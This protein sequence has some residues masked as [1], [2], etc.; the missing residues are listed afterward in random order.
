MLTR[1]PRFKPGDRVIVRSSPTRHVWEIERR[2]YWR[3]DRQPAY[4]L[5]YGSGDKV[6]VRYAFDADLEP[7]DPIEDNPL[8]RINAELWPYWQDQHVAS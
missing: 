8:A 2:D 7:F 5:R 6:H 3:T 1:E 4:R